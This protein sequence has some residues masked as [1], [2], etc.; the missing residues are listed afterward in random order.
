[1]C[2]LL[3]VDTCATACTIYEVFNNMFSTFIQ[4]DSNRKADA[5]LSENESDTCVLIV[6][7]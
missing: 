4:S 6:N 7:L 5:A 2:Y 3:Y 1:M